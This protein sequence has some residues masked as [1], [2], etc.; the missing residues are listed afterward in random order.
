LG[1]L[2]FGVDN[3]LTG[4]GGIA[5]PIRRTKLLD[6]TINV[7]DAVLCVIATEGEYTEKQYF[8]VFA[9]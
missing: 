5:M 4:N 7:R 6:R 1:L 3:T 8:S 9:N 2:Y